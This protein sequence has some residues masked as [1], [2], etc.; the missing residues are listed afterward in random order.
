MRR[1]HLSAGAPNKELHINESVTLDEFNN[2]L[3][4]SSNTNVNSNERDEP[5]Q[6]EIPDNAPLNLSFASLGFRYVLARHS[7]SL[8]NTSLLHRILCGRNKGIHTCPYVFAG[9]D[10]SICE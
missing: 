3:L 1:L 2:P 9:W 8:I 4:N 6:Q 5:P 10:H 7:K